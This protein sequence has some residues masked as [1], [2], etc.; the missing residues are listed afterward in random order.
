MH[1][2]RKDFPVPHQGKFS[3]FLKHLEIE[4]LQFHDIMINFFSVGGAHG[5]RMIKKS[6]RM[7]AAIQSR[8]NK[9]WPRLV[10][11]CLNLL[12]GV[13]LAH[14][15]GHFYPYSKP[16]PDDLFQAPLAFRHPVT[17]EPS[18]F[19]VRRFIDMTVEHVLALFDDMEA[20]YKKTKSFSAA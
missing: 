6:I 10:L 11:D 12:P 4:T 16:D 5:H 17:G 8:F 9:R 7:N 14:F 13:D 3:I 15:S 19:S 1:L 18:L 20:A 2:A